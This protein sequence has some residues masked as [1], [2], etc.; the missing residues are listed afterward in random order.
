MLKP[1]DVEP[2]EDETIED[3]PNP[4]CKGIDVYYDWNNGRT[5]SHTP[6]FHTQ[7]K[8]D[9]FRGPKARKGR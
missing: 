6:P 7:S 9:I 8:R 3:D 4:P 5:V 1:E 2:L